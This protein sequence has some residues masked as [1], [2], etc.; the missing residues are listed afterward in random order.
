MQ[1]PSPIARLLRQSPIHLS[2][3]FKAGKV[4]LSTI[5]WIGEPLM[6]YGKAVKAIFVKANGL[7]AYQKAY[8]L[9]QH[10]I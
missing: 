2:A 10:S 7:P 6:P 8:G 5:P 4:I 9:L 1:T 3:S